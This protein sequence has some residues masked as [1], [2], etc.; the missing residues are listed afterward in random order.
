VE[1]TVQAVAALDAFR[2]KRR[3][4]RWFR[5][6]RT[7]LERAVRPMLV[8]MPDVGAHGL[9]QVGEADDQEPVKAFAPQASNPALRVRIRPRRPHRRP[10]HPDSPG[11]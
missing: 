3:G 6:R 10:D 1:Q 9:L 11:N 7:L 2:V 8:V 4:R 5:E